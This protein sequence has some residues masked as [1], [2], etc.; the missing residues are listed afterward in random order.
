MKPTIDISSCSTEEFI[1]HMRELDK[2]STCP[3]VRL[4]CEKCQIRMQRH[5]CEEYQEW[6][7][8]FVVQ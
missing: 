8:R 2:K 3:C 1:E 5:E 7:R 4:R 6:V